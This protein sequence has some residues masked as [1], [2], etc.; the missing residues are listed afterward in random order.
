MFY[1]NMYIHI[2]IYTVTEK[3]D[4]VFFSIF[5]LNMYIHIYITVIIIIYV[6]DR[7]DR[8]L[9]K[10]PLIASLEEDVLKNP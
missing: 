8:H 1:L 9:W 5:Y 7:R 2:Y 3:H 10:R 6:S 4:A